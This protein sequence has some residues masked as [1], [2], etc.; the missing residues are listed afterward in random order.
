MDAGKKTATAIAAALEAFNRM[1]HDANLRPDA[2]A[3]YLQAVYGFGSPRTLGK[4]R[5]VGGGP[6]FSKA[7][8]SIV[9]YTKAALDTWA[10]SKIG[11]PVRSTSEA[12]AA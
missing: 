1:P 8:P 11:A 9:L 5:C 12:A 10:R 7:G 3:A 4:L 6:A 2:A